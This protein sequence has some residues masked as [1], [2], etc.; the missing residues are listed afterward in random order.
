MHRI[1]LISLLIS[2]LLSSCSS[3]DYITKTEYIT[4]E[5]LILEE[6]QKPVMSNIKWKI[7][8]ENA[9]TSKKEL[10]SLLTDLVNIHTYIESLNS[11]IDSYRS[12]YETD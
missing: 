1:L 6:P 8:G 10:E 2:S 4:K 9:Y 5:K 3:V 11:N 7:K 12:Y